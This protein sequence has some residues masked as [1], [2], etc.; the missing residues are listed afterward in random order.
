VRS[1]LFYCYESEGHLCTCW[2]ASKA[3]AYPTLNRHTIHGPQL[4]TQWPIASTRTLSDPMPPHKR[5]LYA[6][7]P[8][9]R[10]NLTIETTTKACRLLFALL[11]L[12]LGIFVVLLAAT[13]LPVAIPVDTLQDHP[14]F[15]S[16][17][18]H[19]LSFAGR[20]PCFL[21]RRY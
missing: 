1:C 14:S 4:Y 16:S 21:P 7:P 13:S 12:M 8:Q 15:C 3:V 6:D 18:N 17:T 19:S 5:F 2:H 11:S 10:R 20:R 9:V